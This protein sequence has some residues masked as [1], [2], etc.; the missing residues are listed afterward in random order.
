MKPTIHCV[1][2]AVDDLQ[3]SLDFYRDGLGLPMDEVL[4]IQPEQDHVPIT[5]PGGLYLVLILRS[6]FQEF[7]DMAEQAVAPKGSSEC[8]LSYF[9]ANREEVDAIAARCAAAGG[10]VATEPSELGWGY[11]TFLKDPDGH[12]WEVLYNERM[13]QQYAGGQT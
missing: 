5:L 6:G 12:F 10:T 4:P 2:L 9:A 7:T 8:I 3:R 1:S 11:A 13:A